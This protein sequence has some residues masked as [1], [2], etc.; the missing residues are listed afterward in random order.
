MKLIDELKRRNVF[1]VGA[2]Y[3]LLGWLVVQVTETVAPALGL[4]DWT[5]RFVIWI[6]VVGLPF[7]LFF[8]W[9]YELTPEGLKREDEVRPAESITPVTGRKLD[10]LL[11]EEGLK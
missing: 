2:T 10:V 6:G 3:V 8:A 11:T 5:L 7:A 4:P 1:R 9:A